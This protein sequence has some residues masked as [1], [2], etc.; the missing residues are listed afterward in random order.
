MKRRLFESTVTLS[1]IFLLLVAVSSWIL[2]RLSAGFV[3]L[4]LA[5]GVA[6]LVAY[7]AY[8]RWNRQPIRIC[9]NGC[10][11]KILWNTPWICGECGHENFN[12][13]RFPLLHHCE[14]CKLESKSYVC[15][16][17]DRII[18]LSEDRDAINPARRIEGEGQ[19]KK[20]VIEA[21]LKRKAQFE[22]T[23][24]ARQR[25]L[26]ER[27]LALDEAVLNA[28]IKAIKK[29]TP[30]ITIQ[31]QLDVL[32]KSLERH[33][34]RATALD[35]AV[36][37]MKELVNEECKGDRIQIR[38]RHLLVDEWRRMQMPEAQ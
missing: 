16:H 31:S 10:G 2:T 5:D 38:R 29:G 9:C 13:D 22:E 21:E 34:Q 12:V 23:Q 24:A 20:E 4:L 30:E 3:A 14:H 27:R 8:L 35:E 17:C 32:F 19:R 15:H 36:R 26:E 18:F 1:A 33:M 25:G 37:R 6:A 11:G 28:Q 7:Y